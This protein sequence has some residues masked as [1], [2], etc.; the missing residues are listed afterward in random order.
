MLVL[1]N[2]LI[3][4]S[5]LPTPVRV[6]CPFLTLRTS[7]LVALAPFAKRAKPLVGQSGLPPPVGVLRMNRTEGLPPLTKSGLL[8][9]TD[10]RKSG[11]LAKSG[12]LTKSGLPTPVG[13]VMP[14]IT[15][16]ILLAGLTRQHKNGI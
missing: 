8:V 13:P 7:L 4:K 1:T 10:E 3:A 9:L 5:G 12:L 11:L 16:A 6:R 14:M 15:S 2:E